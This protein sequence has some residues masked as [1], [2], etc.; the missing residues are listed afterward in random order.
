MKLKI[1]AIVLALIFLL[2][3][4]KS[5]KKEP[6]VSND[7]TDGIEVTSAEETTEDADVTTSAP[8]SAGDNSS[9]ASEES[10]SDRIPTIIEDVINQ[11]T[12]ILGEKFKPE[13]IPVDKFV[14]DDENF[15]LRG[16]YINKYKGS[17]EYLYIPSEI[18][19]KKI[20]TVAG[21]TDNINIKG[22]YIEDGIE[23]ILGCAFWKCTYL[24]YVRLPQGL[25]TIGIQ[26]FDA[27]MFL[28]GIDIPAT[29][30]TI[31]LYAFRDCTSLKYISLPTKLDKATVCFKNCAFAGDVVLPV[32]E[33]GLNDIFNGCKNIT[34]VYV[35]DGVRKI[36][37]T[38]FQDMPSLVWVS[39]P[40]SVTELSKDI[41][42]DN[43][44]IEEIYVVK[45]S[46]AEMM[47][48]TSK[49]ADRLIVVEE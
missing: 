45:G 4:C 31:D 7:S 2:T 9:A 43:P 6:P 5:K 20:K 1:T 8:E 28:K 30:K 18:N 33:S 44:N 19:G 47:L 3:G 41:F 12:Y 26:A 37:W 48:S 23:E 16:E 25:K 29:V 46:Y 10:V 15:E 34:G 27:C 22:V 24:E 40:K 17:A 32:V 49:Y 39:I 14:R 38:T 21:F 36:L 42:E 11:E 35:A 13:E